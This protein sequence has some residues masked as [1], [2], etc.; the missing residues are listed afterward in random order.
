MTRRPTRRAASAPALQCAH[1][2]PPPGDCVEAVARRSDTFAAV[3]LGSNSFHLVIARREPNGSLVIIDRL[4]EMVRLA[5]GLDDDRQLTEDARARALGAL[6]RFG[7][8]LGELPAANVRV[9]GTNTLRKARNAE[10]FVAEAEAALDHR[11]EIVSGMEEARLIYLGVVRSLAQP[12]RRLVMDIGGGSTEFIVG[13]GPEPL[14]KA[15]LHMGCVSHSQRFFG[16]GRITKKAFEAAELAARVELEPIETRFRALQWESAIGAS[17]T[18]KAVA[19]ALQEAGW[20]PG[21]ITSGGL[22][23]LRK[24]LIQ[25]GHVDR[26][27]VPA[28]KPERYEVF[29]GGVAILRAA[30]AALGI[31]EMRFADGALREGILVDLPGRLEHID[32]RGASVER[33][34]SRFHA[35]AE[36][37]A[38]VQETAAYLLDQVAAAWQ[39]DDED[40]WLLRWAVE[41]HEIGL[42]IAHNAYHKHGA[43]IVDNTDLAGFARDQQRQ[44]AALVRAHRRKFP[45]A[46]LQAAGAGRAV[47]LERLAVLLRLAVLMHRSRRDT[48]LPAFT[49]RT[50]RRRI[51]LEFPDEWLARHPLTR[52]DLEEEAGFLGDGGFALGYADAAAHAET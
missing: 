8:R 45:V 39:L 33:L 12:G 15:S 49:V 27:D 22:K 21:T 10:S 52:A 18:I 17:G 41:L 9:V 38:R 19:N 36:Q 20:A 7:E 35:D 5:A 14:A 29:P 1:S 44:L 3:D 28:V 25:D 26:I 11:I 42:D 4:R 48:P 50:G 43:Y 6:R 37:N 2:C 16:D 30:F 34:A 40:R 32:S 47:T 23:K 46:E 31:E 13:D 51:A 24:H